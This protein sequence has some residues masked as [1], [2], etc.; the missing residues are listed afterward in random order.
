MEGHRAIVVV[1]AVVVGLVAGGATAAALPGTP[2]D[3]LPDPTLPTVSVPTV[4]VPTDPITV[5]TTTVPTVPITVPTEP[6]TVPTVTV[7][8]TTTTL[9]TTTTTVPTTT[10]PITTGS[11]LPSLPEG[12]ALPE[13]TAGTVDA[14]EQIVTSS[15]AG[16]EIQRLIVPDAPVV[17]KPTS[18]TI[19]AADPSRPV[20]GVSFDFG[21]AGAKFGESSCR[22]RKA[23]RQATFSVPYTFS[24]SG[25]HVISFEISSGSCGTPARVTAG[26]VTVNVA[27]GQATVRAV[28]GPDA[29]VLSTKCPGADVLPTRANGTKVRT[30][31]LCLLNKVRAIA[32]LR[33]FKNRRVLRRIAAAHSRDMVI[34]RYFDHTEPPS[35]TLLA[36]LNSV[37]WAGSAGENIGYGTA[38]YATARSMMWAWMHST[39]HRDNILDPTYRWVGIAVSIGAPTGDDQFAA[40]YT[41][42]FG[43]R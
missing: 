25:P 35:R 43:G 7:P 34:R 30:A 26:Q 18:F 24:V 9:P 31:T 20:T 11:P 2:R 15:Q 39:G 5:P 14:T 4:S 6:V 42:D 16:P 28:T 33:T 37:H 8:T 32:G 41:T 3:L 38:Y 40:T 29:G 23:D 13:V 36:R 22:T 21:E 12:D 19:A 10:V 1:G 17:G 27:K